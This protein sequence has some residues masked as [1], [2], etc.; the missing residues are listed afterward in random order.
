VAE[1]SLLL[2]AR[3]KA[4]RLD[5]YSSLRNYT[6][7]AVG[8]G[9][10]LFLPALNLNLSENTLP[11][12]FAARRTVGLYAGYNYFALVHHL[13]HHRGKD[14]EGVAYLRR[15]ERLHDLHHHRQVVNFGISTTIWDR[16]FGTFEP[17]NEPATDYFFWSTIRSYWMKLTCKP[18]A[19]S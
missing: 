9:D 7:K 17:T 13:Q 1:V 4:R 15:L 10:I 3:L 18:S 6:K 14:L 8:G 16:L 5:D 2:L 19:T 11:Y 12:V